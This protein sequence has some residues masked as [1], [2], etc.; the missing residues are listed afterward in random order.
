M[1]LPQ[2][3]R[4]ARMTNTTLGVDIDDRVGDLEKALADILGFTPD[5]NIT[6]S[7]FGCDNSGRITKTLLR[8]KAAGPVGIRFL[9]STSAK[10]F[11]L[12]LSG[13]NI[14]IDENTGSEG[15]PAWTDRASM[16]LATGV[17]TFTGIPVGPATDPT[18]D[19]QFV[20]KAFLD[21]HTNSTTPHAAATNLEKTANKGIANGYASLDAAI[22][23]PT[24]QLGGAGA[25]ANKFLRGDQAWAA[26]TTP[27]KFVK[28][29][30]VITGAVATGTATIPYDD[31]IPQSSEGDQ[32]LTKTFTPANAAN[33]LRID[34]VMSLCR[35]AV[36]DMTVALFKDSDTD[37]IA[38]I[39]SIYQTNTPAVIPLS[40]I[41]DAGT[42]NPIAFKVRAGAD[43][44][45]TNT[46]NG[47]GGNRK[48]GGVSAS[49]II[50]T[51][52]EPS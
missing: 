26:P 41:M 42:T 9:D 5:V 37:A 21:A 13:T 23:V 3:L 44:A 6:E 31:T 35:S 1:A 19:N 52:Y 20:R 51:E 47:T 30:G 22:K 32:Y 46:F 50:I 16:A 48:Y 39:G 14:V 25:D 38:A 2:Q 17:W 27:G 45:G 49:S 33:K 34:I 29:E 10:E 4:S 43:T 15:T 40:F 11:R 12:A 8:M 24:A 28:S 18:T 7:P 36:G